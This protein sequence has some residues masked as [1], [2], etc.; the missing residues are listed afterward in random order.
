[1]RSN[2]TGHMQSC[3]ALCHVIPSK[4]THRLM[5]PIIDR[6]HTV[7]TSDISIR[8]SVLPTYEYRCGW[9]SR[10][11]KLHS[12]PQDPLCHYHESA[13]QILNSDFSKSFTTNFFPLLMTSCPSDSR[14]ALRFLIP[15]GYFSFSSP[16][17][18]KVLQYGVILF[19]PS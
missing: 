12:V 6:F 4:S 18:F 7:D 2:R 17:D 14:R 19:F 15:P 1:M 16:P 9:L 13:N 10:Q 11:M 3:F 5:M 8:S